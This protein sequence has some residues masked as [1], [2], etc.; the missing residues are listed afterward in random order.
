MR[1]PRERARKLARLATAWAYGIASRATSARVGL[2][3][4]YHDLADVE[5]DPVRELN[6]AIAADAFASH[7]RHLRRRYRVV[8]AS[9]IVSAVS[10]RRRWQR[11]PVA[12]TFDD[13][14][15]SHLSHAAPALKREG[16]P[17]TIFLSGAGLTGSFSF[18]WQLLQRAWDERL[19]DASL[20]E[21]WNIG[22]DVGSSR[23]AARGIQQM[24]TADRVAVAAELRARIGPRNDVLSRDEIRELAAGGF[25]L[26]F[27]TLAHDDLTLL[28]ADALDRAL[29]DGVSELERVVGALS[30]LSYPHG[31][32]DGRVAAAARAAGFTLAFVVNGAPV[33]ADDDPHLLGRRYPARGT[34]GEFALDIAR[35]LL[36]ASR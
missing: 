5:G 25:E 10:A 18:W 6:A 17:A 8:P 1:T 33:K 36:G 14:L 3:L 22:G 16:L 7:L 2:V 13:D 21:S 35:L 32:A 34:N 26:G 12:I 11:L 9:Q 30:M 29:R 28:D 4:L 19:I 24:S 15:P 27:H 31:S 20:L 23:D